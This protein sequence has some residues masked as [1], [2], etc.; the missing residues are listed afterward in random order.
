MYLTPLEFLFAIW[1]LVDII[2]YVED[3]NLWVSHVVKIKESLSLMSAVSTVGQKNLMAKQTTLSPAECE[4]T[5]E[6]T[7]FKQVLAMIASSC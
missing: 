3:I 7:F 5:Q 4:L 6:K 1:Q 2:D